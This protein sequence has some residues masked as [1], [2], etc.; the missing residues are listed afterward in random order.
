MFLK[1]TYLEYKDKLEGQHEIDPIWGST[2]PKLFDFQKNAVDQGLTMFELYGGVI[3]GDVVGLGKTYVGTALLKYLQLQEYRPLIIC[4]PQLVPMWQRFCTDYEVDV[5]I[6]SRGKLSQDNFELYQDY[7]YKDRDLVLID[8]SHHF[9]NHLS[10]QYENLHQFMQARDAKAILLTATPY[11]NTAM[12][13]KNQIMLF[14]QSS[15]TF[16][17]P[18]NETD[19]DRYFRQI[20][21]G[22]ANLVDLLRNIMIR[23]TRRY[24]LNQWGKE[25]ENGRKYLQVGDEHKY[26]PKRKMETERYDI[27]KVYKRKYEKI[28]GLIDKESL[29]FARY[30]VGLYVKNK[31]KDIQIYKD[32]GIAGTKL[33]GLIRTL[34]LKRMESSLEAFKQSI[35][36]YITTHEIFL[37]LLDQKIMPIG[38]VSYKAMYDI[39]RDDPDSINDPETIEEFKKK[40]KDA[41]ETQYKFEAFEIDKLKSDIENDIETF[42]QINGL[43]TT[44]TWKNDDKLQRLQKL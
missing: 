24:V 11:S 35:H 2:F 23:R 25:D 16:I 17:P 19:L 44:L 14:H 32:L 10:R 12:D 22:D 5:K 6:L 15:K 7:L 3:I 37:E 30:S 40:I 21:N 1:A 43:I 13:I 38:D 29:T 27:N 26:F 8:E 41:G 42:Q 34:L 20:K 28:V 4:P 33:V 18:A 36:H 9:R 31:Y 39:A